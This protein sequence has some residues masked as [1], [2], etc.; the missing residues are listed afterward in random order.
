[1]HI[2]ELER[3][4]ERLKHKKE[5][6][7]TIDDE[8]QKEYEE[9]SE[10]HEWLNNQTIDLETAINSLHEIIDG[11]DEKIEKQFNEN[12]KKINEKFSYYFSILFNGGKSELKIITNENIAEEEE[13]GELEKKEIYKPKRKCITGVDIVATPPGKKLQSITM[14]SGGEKALT[15]IALICAIIANNTS[16]FVVLDEVDAALDEANSNRFA[17]IL[18]ELS[19]KTQFIVITH[20]RATME[21]AQ[22]L[23]GVTMGDDSVSK[24]ISIKLEEGKQFTNR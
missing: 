10:R 22:L 2:A 11:L 12:I 16:P 1:M 6:I 13:N 3:S 15:S 18:E 8:T 20:N 19:K 23:Y 21:K 14:L 4:I 24:L 9:I 17:N 5:L 7:G